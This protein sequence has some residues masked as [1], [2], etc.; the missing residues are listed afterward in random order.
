MHKSRLPQDIATE[1][2]EVISPLLDPNLDK[3]L[4]CEK[5]KELATRF[6][7]SYRTISRWFQRYQQDGFKGLIPKSPV[8]EKTATPAQDNFNEIVDLAI[9]LRRECPTRSVKTIIKILELEG[10][11]APGT[12]CRSTLQ[13]HLQKRG[14]GTKQILRYQHATPA[15]RRFQKSHRGALYQG[16]IKFGPYLPI[17]PKGKMQ[18]TYLAAWIDDATRFIVGA[19]FYANQTTDIIEDSLR[20]AIMQYGQ[21]GALFVDNGKQYRSKWLMHACAKLGI[22]LLHAKEYSPESKGKIER[23]NRTVD[24]FLAECALQKLRTLDELNAFFSIWLNEKY[25]KDAHAGLSGMSPETAWRIDT[26]LI[27]YPP[28]EALREA[29]LHAEERQVDKTGCISFNGS[30]YEVGM[31][32]IGRK[33]DVIYDATWTEEVEIHHKDF[34]PFRA[35]KLAIGENC[36]GIKEMPEQLKVEVGESRLLTSLRQKAAKAKSV[37]TAQATSFSSI[38]EEVHANV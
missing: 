17:G 38:A 16:D 37:P 10:H 36:K 2:F 31:K 3:N 14:Y 25:H 22:K 34:K 20:M 12:V 28:A 21:P 7:I 30:Q 4:F 23:F 5:K 18:Q 26:H 35:R 19:K 8:P 11:I 27:Y 29:F 9:E 33:V 24:S 13:R 15:A 6:S 32:L 1:R